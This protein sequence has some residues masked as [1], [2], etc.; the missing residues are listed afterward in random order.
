MGHGLPVAPSPRVR[1]RGDAHTADDEGDSA[2]PFFCT[3]DLLTHKQQ[4]VIGY[5]GSLRGLQAGIGDLPINSAHTLATLAG[6][7]LIKVTIALTDKGRQ[8]LLRA[9]RLQSRTD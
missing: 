9:P 2:R 5:L 7:G 8:R 1:P 6:R 3:D 4:R